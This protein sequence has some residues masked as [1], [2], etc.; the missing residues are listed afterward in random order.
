MSTQNNSTDKSTSLPTEQADEVTEVQKHTYDP[1][2]FLSEISGKQVVVKIT[3]GILYNGFLQT[4]DGYMNIVLENT[5]E[6]VNGEVK[7]KYREVF[8]RGNNVLYISAV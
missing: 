1:S 8:I 6:I 4:V 3:S 7:S 2:S 5:Q